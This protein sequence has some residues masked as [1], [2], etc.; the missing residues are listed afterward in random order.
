M[1]E[2]KGFQLSEKVYESETTLI[3]RGIR[4]GDHVPV[5]VKALRADYPTREELERFDYEYRVAENLDLPGVVKAYSLEN[6]GH[7]NAIVM[8]DFGAVALDAY[9]NSNAID[10]TGFLEI[11]LAVTD[12]VGDIHRHNIIHKDIK[13]QNMLLNPDTQEIKITDFSIAVQVKKETQSAMNPEKLEGTLAYMSPEQTG[14]MNRS[15]DYR[16]DF[17]SLGVTFYEMLTGRLPFEC[18]DLLELVHAH[19]ARQ[20]V[21]PHQLPTS[22]PF[23]EGNI[24]KVISDIIMKLLAK[25]T[26]D[27][28]QSAYGLK[29]DL[30]QCYQQWQSTGHIEE[31]EIGAQDISDRFQIPETLYGREDEIQVLFDE[32]AKTAA[33]E[34]RMVFVTGPAGIGKSCLIH[35]IHK[36]L[37]ERKGYFISGKFDRYKRIP[38]SALIQ[39]FQELIKQLLTESQARVADW[40]SRLLDA[41]GPNGQVVIDMIPELELIIGQQ[42]PLPSLGST[43]SE[44][45]FNLTFQNFIHVFTQLEHPLVIFIDDWQWADSATLRLLKLMMADS[46]NTYLLFIGAYR[47]NEVDA[48]HPLMTTLNEIGQEHDPEIRSLGIQPLKSTHIRQ[49][50]SD[51]LTCSPEAEPLAKLIERKTQGNPFFV[52]QFLQTLY[53]ENILRYASDT[54]CWEWDMA[55]VRTMEASDNVVDLMVKRLKN[56][57]ESTQE[58]LQLAAYIGNS[59]DLNTLSLIHEQSQE[60]T[61]KDLWQAIEDDFVL[62]LDDNYKRLSVLRSKEIEVESR[63]T[64]SHDRIQQASYSLIPEEKRSA[65]HLKI[66]RLLLN[67]TEAENLEEQI[68]DIVNQ[69]NQSVELITGKAERLKLAELNLIAGKKAKASTAYQSALDYLTTGTAYLSDTSWAE[70]Y[71]STY[72][73]YRELAEVGYLTGNFEQAETISAIT[74]KNAKTI[75][76]KAEVYNMRIV[77]YTIMAKYD[78]AFQAGREALGLFGAELPETDTQAAFN[79]ELGEIHDLLGGREIEAVIDEKEMADPNV[80]ST[81]QIL[82]GLIS[83]A[84]QSKPELFPLIIAKIVKLSLKYGSSRES[85][86]GYSAYSIILSSFFGNYTSG[87]KLLLALKNSEK[88]NIPALQCQIESTLAG[89]VNHW[90]NHMRSSIPLCDEAYKVSLEVGNFQFANYSIHAKSLCVF[91]QGSHLEQVLSEL[92]G[93]LIFTQKTKNQMSE[94]VIVGIYLTVLN[95]TAQ[96][97]D[98]FSFNSTGMSEASYLKTCQDNQLFM[99]LTISHILKAQVLY[100]YDKP[101]E[102]LTCVLEAEKLLPTIMGFIPTAEHNFYHSLSLAALYSKV[103]EPEQQQYWEKLETNQQQM[104]T[105][106]DNCPENFLHKYLL[107]EAEKCRITGND[108]EAA[109]L[110]EQALESARTNGFIQNEALTSEVAARFWVSK[111]MEKFARACLREAYQGYQRWGATRK[112]EDLEKKYS[113]LLS[114]HQF[115]GF[116]TTA[117]SGI[118]D[119]SSTSGSKD[120]LDLVTVTK[121][122]QAISSE[123]HLDKLLTKMMRIVIEN[124]GA[125][126]GLLILNRDGELVIE[127]EGKY[128]IKLQSIVVEDSHDLAK[129]IVNYVALTRASLVLHNAAEEETFTNDA[130]IM[131]AQPKSILCAPI[132]YQGR[133]FGMLY[134]E[135]NLSTGVFTEE[136]LDLL[137]LLSAQ[138]AISIENASLFANL[139]ERIRERTVELTRAYEELKNSQLQLVESAKLASIGELATGIAHEL[140]QP[141]AYI[142]GNAQMELMGGRDQFDPDSAIETLEVVVEGTERMIRIINH[143]KEFARQTGT[144]DFVR[145][146]VGEILSNSFILLDEQFKDK[147]ISVVKYFDDNNLSTVFGNS[148]QLEQVFINMFTNARDALKDADDPVLAVKTECREQNLVVSFSDNGRGIPEANLGK[149]FDPFF[150]TKDVGKGTGLGLSISYGIIKEHH[151]DICVSSVEGEGTTFEIILPTESELI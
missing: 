80:Q 69:L 107:V 137:Q 91:Y 45:R 85:A 122:S 49:L 128:E 5:I 55:A 130:Y 151:G 117:T 93:G 113:E 88:Y 132:L 92:S 38:Y 8:E 61:L 6:T 112:V 16:S 72:A 139:E 134:L 22:V 74:L 77:H 127:A 15:L 42:P 44:N 121:A 99:G 133:L 120:V 75:V 114:A 111:G 27:R 46:E 62:P 48:S 50:I 7:S 10:L 123:V 41:L 124:T 129:S 78:E 135:N 90:V 4:E 104:K 14:R 39:A 59:F 20:P 30:E 119:T 115:R 83:T 68:F 3:Y 102:A 101:A 12:I 9:L 150:S 142:R 144:L 26:E 31:F 89:M 136:R 60:T 105:W 94:S 58:V 65:L 43:E 24:P 87:Y 116:R 54:L 98:R 35:E 19:I 34:T 86:L 146:D 2:L 96:T 84:F 70:K 47:D 147:N 11:A 67:A 29:A 81:V 141:L 97:E 131:K 13:P 145:V 76:E 110:Y 36:P 138:I 33:G 64:F 32:F 143:L 63:F 57:P 56:L 148:N 40:K 118:K 108:W 82:E 95:L 18:D 37:V 23:Q 73:L 79:V 25:A 28:Y 1:F 103:T 125:E 109:T 149:I 53:Q 52:T 66:G 51:A 106:A 140:N 17:Y 126:R 21:P 71:E 100:L